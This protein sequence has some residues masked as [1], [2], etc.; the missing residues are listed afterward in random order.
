MKMKFIQSTA[1]CTALAMLA[2]CANIQND[3]TRTR[4]EGALAG[5]AL[6]A[7]AGGIIGNQ[8]GRAWEGALIGAAAGGL[9]GLAVGDSVARKKARYA[10]QEAWLDACISQAERVNSKAVAYNRSLSQRIRELEGRYSRAKASGDTGEMRKIKQ[11]VVVMQTESRKE[12]Q[13]VDVEIKDQTT[14]VSET[15]SSSLRSRVSELRS[16]RSSISSNQERLADLG[17][18]IDV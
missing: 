2:S 3:Q 18:Q 8:S 6:G 7:L 4:T 10:S 17:N 16:T 15:G 12:V 5:G 9:A 13:R 11:A 1:A 14:V